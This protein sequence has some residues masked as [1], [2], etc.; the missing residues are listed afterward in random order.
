MRAKAIKLGL[1][2]K[3]PAYCW[4]SNNK[5]CFIKHLYKVDYFLQ[6][7]PHVQASP[8]LMAVLVKTRLADTFVTVL[9]VT[10]EQTVKPVSNYIRDTYSKKPGQFIWKAGDP[11]YRP[12]QPV[13]T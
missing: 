3:Y 4:D 2:D 10:R 8:V 11:G 13:F 9:Q 6:K 1:W 7:S 5:V 12:I